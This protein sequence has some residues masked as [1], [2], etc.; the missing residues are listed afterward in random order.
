MSRGS[1]WVAGMKSGSVTTATGGSDGLHVE[2]VSVE[3]SGVEGICRGGA[4]VVVEDVVAVREDVAGV[5]DEG[6]V[7]DV[8]V[9]GVAGGTVG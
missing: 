8:R 4:V 6:G 7:D 3:L 1:L 2:S 5:K 9:E